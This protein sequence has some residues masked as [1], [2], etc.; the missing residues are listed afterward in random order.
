MWAV[1]MVACLIQ[2]LPILP[3]RRH[4][5]ELL[6]LSL[7]RF[8]QCPGLM[9]TSLTRAALV[10]PIT[11]PWKL[12][13]NDAFR[14]VCKPCCLTPGENR[15]TLAAVIS[16]QR[17]GLAGVPR[18]KIFTTPARPAVYRLTILHTFSPGPRYMRSL[19]DAGKDG[20]R[21]VQRLGFSAIGRPT[22]F[23]KRGRVSPITSRS[24]PGEYSRQRRECARQ[25]SATE[26]LSRPV[27]SGTSSRKSGS[28]VSEDS[29]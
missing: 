23:C 7:M 8:A 5:T 2:D 16:M 27:C 1:R 21:V 10:I 3:V 24:P 25:L 14:L 9:R 4:Q 12:S 13:F 15:L 6:I 17:M 29:V 19:R 11:T 18:C 20:S 26:P 22:I 28:A